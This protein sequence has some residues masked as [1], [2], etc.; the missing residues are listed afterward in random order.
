MKNLTIHLSSIAPLQFYP[1]EQPR[2]PALEKLLS[3]GRSQQ[4]QMTSDMAIHA[5]A[6]LDNLSYAKQRLAGENVQPNDA[7]SGFWYCADPVHLKADRD[8]VHLTHSASI[9]IQSVEADELIASFNRLFKEDGIQL[10]S[11]APERWYLRSET[12]WQLSTTSIEQVEDRSIRE[13][14]PQGIDALRWSKVLAEVEMLFLA[15]Q[16]TANVMR[17]GNY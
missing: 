11:A 16:S 13:L 8:Q 7:D 10:Y 17:L 15:I 6:A 4:L 12:P 9:N 5:E 3:R 1:G 2:L 14:M